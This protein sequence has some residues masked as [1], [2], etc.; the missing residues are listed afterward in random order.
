MIRRLNPPNAFAARLGEQHPEPGVVYQENPFL[1]KEGNAW[2]NPLTGEAAYVDDPIQERMRLIRRWYYV[3]KDFDIKAATHI[4]RQK[5]LTDRAAPIRRGMT[6]YVIFTTTACN[7]ACSY[8]FEKDLKILTMDDKTALDAAGFIERTRLKNAPVSIKWFGGEPLCNTR[9]IDAITDYLSRKQIPF[10]SDFTTNGD[11][12]DRVPDGKLLHQ[13][14]TREIQ[15]TLDDVGEQYGVHKG[16]DAGAFDRLRK[17]VQRIGDLGLRVTIRVHYHADQGLEPC[18]R[19]VDAFRGMRN[20]RMYGRI[21]YKTESPD[22]YEN[23]LRLED[24]MEQAGFF[25]RGFPK[26]GNG[27][28]CMGDNSRIACIT[29]DGHLSPC[30]HYAYGEVYGSIY[31]GKLDREMLAEWQLREKHLCDCGSCP[32]YPSCEKLMMCPAEGDCTKGYR[33]YQIES[34]RRAL[35]NGVRNMQ[36]TGP[37]TI[38]AG[39][40]PQTICGVC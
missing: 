35:R 12:L 10:R 36:A 11:L 26:R 1:I 31:G 28:H 9:A 27:T 17:T 23:L 4:V 34:I 3:P 20:V 21:I 33:D 2:Y 24:Y 15:L 30:E 16:L 22:D 37:K 5:I 38:Q 6:S 19:V 7:A 32:L 29:P 8:C 18:F 14:R 13:W 39:A 25:S 40:D